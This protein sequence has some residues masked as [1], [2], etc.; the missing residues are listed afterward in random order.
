MSAL[1]V[2][3]AA[4]L[5]DVE[6]SLRSAGVVLLEGPAGIGKTAVFRELVDR[7]AAAGALVLSCA[8]TEAETALPL[9]AVADL[10]APVAHLVADLPDAQRAAVDAALS[11]EAVVDERAL[12]AAV[13]S[14]LEAAARGRSAGARR[15][16]R[17]ARGWIRRASAR[18]G[19]PC[20]GWAARLPC[21]PLRAPARAAPTRCRSDCSPP[22]R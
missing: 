22:A 20:G 1:V 18:C 15:G 3:R 7:A 11:G 19:T 12:S 13:R 6:R 8:P 10:L 21:S 14:L 4:V 17:R 5:D 9:A 16:R 2:G